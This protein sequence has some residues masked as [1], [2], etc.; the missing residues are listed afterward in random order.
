MPGPSHSPERKSNAERERER[1]REERTVTYTPEN[2]DRGVG[3]E[4]AMGIRYKGR[5]MQSF[6]QGRPSLLSRGA[7]MWV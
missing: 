5:V 2:A 1:A 4:H 3:E 7:A 6:L